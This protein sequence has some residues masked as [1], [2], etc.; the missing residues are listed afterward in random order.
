M[1]NDATQ[2]GLTRESQ[3]GQHAA[4]LAAAGLLPALSHQ[5]MTG[6]NAATAAI[7][8]RAKAQLL[9]E[10]QWARQEELLHQQAALPVPM[11]I[12]SFPEVATASNLINH[13]HTLSMNAFGQAEPMFPAQANRLTD[14]GVVPTDM[15]LR[16]AAGLSADSTNTPMEALPAAQVEAHAS[17]GRSGGRN[18]GKQQAVAGNGSPQAGDARKNA[19]AKAQ[20]GNNTETQSHRETLRRHLEDLKNVDERCIFI[21]RRINKLGFRSRLP[22]EQH[23]SKYGKVVQV[24]VAH[25]K[26]KPFQ[27]TGSQPRTRPGNFG[28]VVMDSPEAVQRV[29]AE[30]VE[31]VVAGVQVQVQM[32]ERPNAESEESEEMATQGDMLP[33]ALHPSESNGQMSGTYLQRDEAAKMWRYQGPNHKASEAASSVHSVPVVPGTIDSTDVGSQLTEVLKQLSRISVESDQLHCLTREQSLH[34]A[35]LAQFAQQHLRNLEEQCQQKFEELTMASNSLLYQG[36]LPGNVPAAAHLLGVLPVSG[37]SLTPAAAARGMQ[38]VDTTTL[39]GSEPSLPSM[40]AQAAANAMVQEAP[41][42]EPHNMSLGAAD[43]KDSNAKQAKWQP[44]VRKELKKS[45]EG[46]SQS[47]SRDTLRSHLTQLSKEDPK[48]IFIVRRIN[49]L[50]FRSRDVL[51]AHFAHYGEVCKVLVAHSKVKPFRDSDGQLKTRPGGLGLVVM[52]NT[53]VVDKIL[54]EGE[55]QLV[56]GHQIRVSAFEKPQVT[57]NASATGSNSNGSG[58]STAPGSNSNDSASSRGSQEKSEEGSE[59]GYE[60]SDDM[61]AADGASAGSAAGSADA[62]SG[63]TNSN[64]SWQSNEI[65]K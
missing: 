41:R 56:A 50:G 60:K 26:V 23:F 54:A 59:G 57:Y 27:H 11:G 40:V 7:E 1:L 5:H 39:P 38:F 52:R 20:K 4:A 45:L 34:T 28:L 31:Q 14:L 43:V 16:L 46:G 35:S 64:D 65:T 32:F 2:F 55:E 21:T 63:D 47:A 48:C 53:A 42:P 29:L 18:S 17:S 19:R 37:Q 10:L 30:G 58:V 12:P 6:L 49:K 25:S 36:M 3:V 33:E 44:A 8:A 9:L 15:L 61:D 13:P 62:G 51:R 24:L 22:L